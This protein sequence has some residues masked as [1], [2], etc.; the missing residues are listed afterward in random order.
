MV[1]KQY[2]FAAPRNRGLFQLISTIL[3]SGEPISF[4][5]RCSFHLGTHKCNRERIANTQN[6]TIC[7]CIVKNKI[8]VT[9][10]LCTLLFF[11]TQRIVFIITGISK[12]SL[13]QWFLCKYLNECFIISCIL[14]IH[15][16]VF[17]IYFK[18]VASKS[19][20]PLWFMMTT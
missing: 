16:Y 4:C 12:N 11:F 13:H 5:C 18:I 10:L 15:K 1:C 17:R 3:G 8:H 19:E 7:K 20:E 6:Y 2:Q 14:S 9:E